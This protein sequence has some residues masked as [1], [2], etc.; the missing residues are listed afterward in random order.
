LYVISFSPVVCITTAIVRGGGH[1]T[2]HTHIDG[3][4]LADLAKHVCY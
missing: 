4:Y 1:L 3:I 2:I